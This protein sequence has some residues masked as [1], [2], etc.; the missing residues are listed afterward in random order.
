MDIKIESKIHN[1]FDIEVRDAKTGELKQRGQAENIVL[2]RM[3]TRL[4]NFNS[5]F[6]NI[7]FGKGTGTLDPSRTTLFNRLGS[8]SAVTEET[9]KDFPI[10]RW[11]RKI[12]LNPEEFV[13][14][15]ITEVGISDDSTNI[16]THALIK[17]AEGNQ[18]SIDKTDTD[19]VIIY[20]T[21]FIELQNRSEN[22]YFTNLTDNNPLLN[23]LLGS[24]APSNTV[25]VGRKWTKGNIIDA[26]V[27]L[28]KTGTRTADIAN[29]K[30]I[31]NTL[32]F[33]ITEG[34]AP[35]SE[36]ECF[37][38]FK[39]TLPETGVFNG[40][41]VSDKQIGIGDGMS[42]AFRLPHT[43]A[44]D[45]NVKV[46]NSSTQ[47]FSIAED[48]MLNFREL[49]ILESQDSAITDIAISGDD[50]TLIVV[51]DKRC[52]IYK[53]DEEFKTYKKFQELIEG[54][55][56]P[57]SADLTL[58]GET[59]IIYSDS[60][61]YLYLYRYDEELNKYVKKQV[62]SGAAS[63]GISVGISPDGKNI[64]TFSDSTPRVATFEL[65]N[66]SD[67]Y[68]KIQELPGIG[69]SLR[70]GTISKDGSIII[71]ASYSTPMFVLFRLNKDTQRYEFVQQLIGNGTGGT[72]VQISE[73]N[74]L[75]VTVSYY[76]PRFVVHR[77]NEE[78][79]MY[80]QV[81]VLDANTYWGEAVSI[82]PGSRTIAT[83]T[84]NNDSFSHKMHVINYNTSEFEQFSSM[85]IGVGRWGEG[86][87]VTKDGKIGA[88]YSSLSGLPII[89]NF[90]KSVK[91]I[92]FNTPPEEGAIITA[93]YIVPYI[94]KTEDY[95]LDITAEIQFGEGV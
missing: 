59:I 76:D 34:N 94:P 81:Q 28:S 20:A 79:D 17:D 52:N 16:N 80:E 72:A 83:F 38:S 1:R 6:T 33:G 85:S 54:L 29:K 66:I 56:R 40:H 58:N 41:I 36:I 68:S 45:I 19:V 37:G 24:S 74:K 21:V 18:L 88:A 73:D 92:M 67:E 57:K 15:T 91:T 49:N 35:I 61:P 53:L 65:D 27:I 14:N 11:T 71:S 43:R 26:N 69:S 62:I 48:Y 2:D 51:S 31:L 86:V 22:I 63:S 60:S 90:E 55:I 70:D 3:Y 44:E 42:K 95:V 32:R 46:N 5:Y 39:V 8:K 75:I 87:V 4:C 93:D 10:S 30:V 64:V 12:T 47:T 78:T 25:K 9:V 77:L 13:G 23:Y 50:S 7:V 89:S 82:F 84:S